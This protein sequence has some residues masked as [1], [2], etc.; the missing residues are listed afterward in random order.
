MKKR[1]D[2][3]GFTG[4]TFLSYKGYWSIHKKTAIIYV[5]YYSSFL[6][7]KPR[8]ADGRRDVLA[9]SDAHPLDGQGDMSM[10]S[11]SS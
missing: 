3:L 8:T 5:L 7:G 10:E 1:P 2:D 11:E 6:L 4:R 9:R